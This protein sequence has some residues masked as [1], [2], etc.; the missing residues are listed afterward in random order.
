VNKAM[1]QLLENELS[2]EVLEFLELGLQHEQ[3]HQELLV[4]DLKYTLGTNPTFPVYQEKEYSQLPLVEQEWIK[5]EAGVYE[6]GFEGNGFSFDNE[7]PRHRTFL[8][9]YAIRN[10]LITNSAK[11]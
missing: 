2:K 5:V 1:H 11:K 10:R 9:P 3:Q 8:E 6:I 7:T 4:T